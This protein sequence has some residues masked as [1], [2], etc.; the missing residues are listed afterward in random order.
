MQKADLSFL[1]D[2]LVGGDKTQPAFEEKL[3]KFLKNHGSDAILSKGYSMTEASSLATF[4]N[5]HVNELGSV[6]IP[7]VKTAVAAFEPGTQNEL[8]YG[9]IGELCIKSTNLMVEYYN[10]PEETSKVKQYHEDGYWIH[11]GDIGYVTNNGVV[12]IKDRI[13]RMIIRSGFKVFPSEIEKTISNIEYVD[14]C[15]VVGIDDDIDVTA[16]KAYIVVNENCLKSE[17]E[18]IDDIYN[19]IDNSKLP[20]YFRP[21]DIELI[22]KMPTTLIGKIDYDKLKSYNSKIKKMK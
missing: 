5:K 21:V 10:N 16:P 6:G 17:K 1:E 12:Y 14:V 2:V 20:P 7:L 13:K 11:S 4:S 15:A 22:E 3:N 18:I 9:Q 8:E 19:V